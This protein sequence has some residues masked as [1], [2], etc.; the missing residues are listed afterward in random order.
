MLILHN[1]IIENVRM[2]ANF[3]KAIR[4]LIPEICVYDHAWNWAAINIP[5]T[6]AHFRFISEHLLSNNASA[7]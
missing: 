7:E 2:Y 3:W 5:Y 4:D 1:P 6:H